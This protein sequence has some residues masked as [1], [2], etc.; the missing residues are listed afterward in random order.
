[1]AEDIDSK[2]I[3]NL[4]VRLDESIHRRAKI[5][6]AEQGSSFQEFVVS[7]IR[8]L[9][10]G[11]DVKH[12]FIALSDEDVTLALKFLYWYK[13]AKGPNQKDLVELVSRDLS[14]IKQIP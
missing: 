11:K 12:P 5:K 8:E 1:M 10:R 14:R 7:A 2:E 9:L 3:K 13:N 4:M 6:L